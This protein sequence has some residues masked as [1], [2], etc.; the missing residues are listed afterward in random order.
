[1]KLLICSA[2]AAA[3][4]GYLAGS[5]G[6]HWS[7]P[8][9][10]SS[11]NTPASS[12]DK[13]DRTAGNAA[14]SGIKSPDTI[15]TLSEVPA[16]ELYDRLALWLLDAGPSDM[17][18]FWADYSN[19]EDRTN[20]LND[21][22]FINWTRVDPEAAIAAAEGTEF[23]K[24]PWWAWA[25]HEPQKALK[26]VL[27]RYQGQENQEPI[28]NVMWGLGEFHP[29]W[30]REHIDELPEK[31][32]K[33]RALSGY[34]KWADTESPRESIDFLKSRGWN[35][36]PKTLAALGM[37]DPG[38]AY[39][40]AL[41]LKGDEK[42]YHYSDLPDQLIDSL[43]SQDPALLDQLLAQTKSPQERMKI[44]L[45]QFEQLLK[46]DPAAAEEK[47]KQ[48]PA[49]WA[50]ED[51][52]SSL[53]KSYLAENPAKALELTAL[54]LRETKD[55]RFRMTTVYMEGGSRGYGAGESPVQGLVE[56]LIS[57][58]GAELM[59]AALPSNE[60]SR[61]NG[62][63]AGDSSGLFDLPA[64]NLHSA[65]KSREIGEIWARHDLPAFA[66]WLNKQEDPAAY[67]TGASTL[68][69]HL[70]GKGHY[71]EAMEWTRSLGKMEESHLNN[72]KVGN[73]YEQWYRNDPEAARAWKA[74]ANL[75]ED[76]LNRIEKV[77]EQQQ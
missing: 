20:D 10:P 63:T 71:S 32:M 56:Q 40:I 73:T 50:R 3:G 2:V 11:G 26:E 18:E 24:Y 31:W 16:A 46:T 29:A 13:R 59:E 9:P 41:E 72:H 42:N 30:L 14:P 21:L 53:A 43:A 69:S 48:L 27:A 68:I 61:V 44:Q 17:Q 76:L 37:E 66:E 64:L 45:K 36:H 60:P 38:E 75:D 12:L 25:C 7:G 62:G 34:I 8:D 58:H 19:R 77:E 35:I 70:V 74:D 23:A 5:W 54:L 22:V 4:M 6:A 57:T 65:N 47:A 55:I 1:M 67:Q 49:G 15:A 39:R 28:G 51:Q 52:L 33:D